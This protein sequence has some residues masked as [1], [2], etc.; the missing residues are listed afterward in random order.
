MNKLQGSPRRNQIDKLQ[1]IVQLRLL[2]FYS[3]IIKCAKFFT[4][5]APQG[6]RLSLEMT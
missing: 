6:E 5:R 4:G 2:R 3:Y 1:D